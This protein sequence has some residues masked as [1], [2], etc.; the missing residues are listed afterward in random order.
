MLSVFHLAAA[1]ELVPDAASPLAGLGR[2]ALAKNDR[3]TAQRWLRAA[4]K[5]DSSD[6]DVRALHKE[7][8]R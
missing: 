4:E 7:L 1:H 8:E 2:V 5:A 6:A 3:S